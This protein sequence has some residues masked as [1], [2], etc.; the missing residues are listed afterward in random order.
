[1]IKP[2]PEN[3][4]VGNS[5][6]TYWQGT[7]KAGAYASGGASHPAIQ[8]FWQRFFSKEIKD[9]KKYKLL[10]IAS[11]NGA[12]IECALN[13][14]NGVE[15]KITT[16]DISSAAIDN[17]LRRFPS[18]EGLVSDARS[19]QRESGSFDIVTSQFGVE[20]AGHEAILESARLV[21]KEG[22]LVF[23][24]HF[25]SGSIHKECRESLEA[26]NSL[27]ESQFI[28]LAKEMFNT[29]FEAVR[30]ADRTNYEIAAKKLAPALSQL[31]DIMRKYGLHVAGDTIQ[32]LYNDVGEIHKRMQ[33]YQPNDVIGWLDKM[34][35]ELSAYASRMSSMCS[36]AINNVDF[37]KIKAD[38]L[39]RGFTLDLAEPLMVSGQD[40]PMAWAL[41]ARK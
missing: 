21:A 14:L 2:E 31:E 28:P 30:G 7:G 8:L 32:K 36:S 17:I 24:L 18:V 41:I 6:N 20:Y 19:I 25:D 10:D 1:M 9:S 26:I 33:H 34:N 11:G 37:E 23:L 13:I 29:G 5:W 38:I 35:E 15:S 22:I 12:V 4:D 27:Q 40:K 16:L 3:I 39:A